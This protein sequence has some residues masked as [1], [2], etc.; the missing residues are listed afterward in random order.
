MPSCS[1]GLFFLGSFQGIA[2]NRQLKRIAG[3]LVACK[4]AL[5]TRWHHLPLLVQT[6]E[7]LV[8]LNERAIR[9]GGADIAVAFWDVEHQAA[10]TV[11]D[12]VV[13]DRVE[14]P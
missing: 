6:A 13:S 8:E 14:L 3:V 11:D 2:I 9:G 7:I 10:V 1:F 12:V 5:V 4:L